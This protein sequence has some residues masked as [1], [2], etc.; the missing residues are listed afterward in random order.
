MENS[1]LSGY[2]WGLLFINNSQIIN[3]FYV[4]TIKGWTF[5]IL[6][7]GNSTLATPP[8]EEEDDW[9][10]D[11]SSEVEDEGNKVYKNP[12]NSPSTLCPRDEEQATLLVAYWCNVQ[13]II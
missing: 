2:E 13:L 9:D 12:R 3:V 6:V 4:Y 10:E 5:P 8:D 7:K 1:Q 11:E